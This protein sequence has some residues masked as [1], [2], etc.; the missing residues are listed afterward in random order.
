MLSRPPHP[1]VRE[2]DR[3]PRITG[4]GEAGKVQEDA[5]L[6]ADTGHWAWAWAANRNRALPATR[7]GTVSR[8]PCVR[9]R[10]DSEGQFGAQT[11]S[12]SLRERR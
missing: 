9:V 1:L 3:R 10:Q 11:I 2:Q 6:L 4:C 12:P 7:S 5:S 8:S